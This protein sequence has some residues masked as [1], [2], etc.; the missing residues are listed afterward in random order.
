MIQN[1][2]KVLAPS[3]L[4][5]DKPL[6]SVITAVYNAEKYLNDCIKSVLNQSYRDFEYIIIDG[7]STDNT[8]DIVRQYQH[9]I[10]YWIS[11]PDQ[12]IYDAWNKGLMVAK[13]RW[14]TFVGADDLLYP[15]ALQTYIQHIAQ[16]PKPYELEFVSSRIELVNE[17][18]SPIR[19]VGDPWE[20]ERFKKDM[21][22]WHVGTF[23]S[24]NLFAKYGAFDS[25]YKSAGDYEL[26]MRPKDQLVASFIDQVTVKMRT[27]G[28]SSVQ[29][30]QAI[31]ET[32]NAKIKNGLIP[33]L[34]G[35]LLK[36]VDKLR[37]FIGRLKDKY[38][39]S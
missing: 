33:P 13:G 11:E 4:T 15:H 39:F 19:T 10:S 22:T 31:N 32:Y 35:Q 5:T 24:K 30:Y 36:F 29:L 14:I 21:C 6:I 34:K 3:S 9:Q 7:G 37:L 1:S 26:L 20:W 16:Y 2:S 17:D 18:L 27:G 25:I 23:H 12:G 28:V 8:L 38:L